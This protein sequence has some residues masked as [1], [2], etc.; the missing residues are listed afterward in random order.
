MSAQNLRHL[1]VLRLA[2]HGTYDN[3]IT[4]SASATVGNKNANLTT[5]VSTK[6]GTQAE[7]SAGL[8]GKNVYAIASY[9][10]TVKCL[11]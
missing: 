2:L 11:I 10:Y 4:A 3:S 5:G 1:G 8:D 7:A 6:T 9:S